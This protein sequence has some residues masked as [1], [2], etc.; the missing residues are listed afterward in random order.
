MASVRAR[1]YAAGMFWE[2]WYTDSRG[3]RSGFN[4]KIPVQGIRSEKAALELTIFYEA[5]VRAGIDIGD[6]T[7]ADRKEMFASAW[8]QFVEEK[9]LA[10]RAGTVGLYEQ[11]GQAWLRCM[12]NLPVGEIG[13]EQLRQFAE[14]R[15]RMA[16]KQGRM[17]R[18][19]VNRNLRDLR[20]FLRWCVEK[21]LIARA[22]KVSPLK[23]ERVPLES[24]RPEEMERILVAAAE[25]TISG[26]RFDL[27]LRVLLF[28]ALR[29][30]EALSL[31][32]ADVDVRRRVLVVAGARTK[33]GKAVTVPLSLP[34][35]AALKELPT[36]TGRM[37]PW[38]GSSGHLRDVWVA[39][40]QAAGVRYLKLHA[41][42]HTAARMMVEAGL[43]PHQ[44]REMLHASLA[45][46]LQ[47]YVSADREAIVDAARRIGRS[48]FATAAQRKQ[49]K[50]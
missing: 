1:R 30:S 3:K 23:V 50:G 19:T 45:T 26:V 42:R 32:W 15:L 25:R 43:K 6:R 35:I 10:V 27:F 31:S 12:D 20:H 21:G 5:N 2:G 36:R 39:T 8:S 18:Q 24:W 22:P 29:L 40:V 49:T 44:L 47:Y 34:L 7:W 41:L 37:F 4:T 16:G 14:R 28:S 48:P 33:H 38:S 13:A 9:R 17:T 46:T 11:T